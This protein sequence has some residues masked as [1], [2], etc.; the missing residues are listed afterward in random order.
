MSEEQSERAEQTYEP[1]VRFDEQG[2][3][4]LTAE[5]MVRSP[6]IRKWVKWLAEH[7]DEL[8]SKRAPQRQPSGSAEAPISP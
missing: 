1:P 6:Q 4:Y 7:G 2:R 5:D 8:L 3:R